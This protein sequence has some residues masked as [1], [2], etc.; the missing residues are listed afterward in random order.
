MSDIDQ[1]NDER[2]N[3]EV[4][5]KLKLSDKLWISFAV[6]IFVIAFALIVIFD[7]F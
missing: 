2:L 7:L 3:E 6:G 1:S 5:P 4:P